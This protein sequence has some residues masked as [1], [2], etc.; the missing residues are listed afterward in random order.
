MTARYAIGTIGQ[1][2]TFEPDTLG[3][4]PELTTF[5]T[6][7]KAQT[8]VR[9]LIALWPDLCSGDKLTNAAVYD[10]QEGRVVWKQGGDDDRGTV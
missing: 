5:R 7:R 8:E 4:D 6:L 2:G 9:K 3:N 1:W 10:E